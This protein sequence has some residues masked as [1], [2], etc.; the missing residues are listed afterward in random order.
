MNFKAVDTLTYKHFTT[1]PDEPNRL[2]AAIEMVLKEHGSNGHTKANINDIK[3]RLFKLLNNIELVNKALEQGSKTLS[4]IKKDKTYHLANA[5]I[6]ENVVAKRFNTLN[7]GTDNWD[8][9]FEHSYNE[10]VSQLPYDL[11]EEQIEAIKISLTH[12]ISCITGG[13]G[14]GK[15]TV[16]RTVLRTYNE[17]GNTI[18]PVT[19]SGRAAMRLHESIGFITSTIARL[20]R[21]SPIE[22]ETKSILVIDEASMIDIA[23][24]YRLVT[25]LHPSVRMLFVGDPN[26]LPPIGA[27]IVLADMIKSKKIPVS[28]LSIVKRQDEKSGIPLYSKAIN[29]GHIPENLSVG[30]IQFH[31]V[32]NLNIAQYCVN[33]MQTIEGDCK[34]MAPTKVLVKEINQLGQQ[35]L[36]PVGK[37]MEVEDFGIIYKT[38][39]RLGDPVIFT[40]NNYNAGVQNGSLGRLISVERENDIWG[41]V[42]LDDGHEIE[43]DKALFDSLEQAYAITLHKAQGSQFKTVIVALSYSQL[44]DRAWLYTA[45]TRSEINLHIVGLKNTFKRAINTQSARYI[46]KTALADLIR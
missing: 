15:T 45:V 8:I 40:A 39:F 29:D 7:M 28:E 31:D 1:T 24:M 32:S 2:T 12:Q 25:H 16:L 23:T 18:I 17:L 11:T 44:I 34:I 9:Q 30:N 19:L 14:T 37:L 6:M 43:L 41:V 38:D 22:Q 4:F 21:E 27:G 26:Q 13:A 3:P 42:K 20:L 46:R 35:T 5:Y 36:N 10:A 33:L